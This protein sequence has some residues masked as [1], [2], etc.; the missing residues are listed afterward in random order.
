[1][2]NSNPT[3]K[4]PLSPEQVYQKI[5]AFCTFRDR[6]QKEVLEKLYAIGA[7]KDIA[8][9]AI[10]KLLDEGYLN[11]D[12]MAKSYAGGK[13]RIKAWGRKKIEAHM[14]HLGLH[15]DLIKKGLAQIDENDYEEKLKALAQKK[16]A[17][18]S[19]EDPQ[20]RI[21]KTVRY[22]ASKGYESDKVWNMVNSLNK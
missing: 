8:K 15:E 20:K 18:L 12:R 13:F 14:K 9:K 19:Q 21:G 1:M 11:E 2:N 10:S 3:H 7:S 22:L 4:K 17:S 16:W 5:T 6:S